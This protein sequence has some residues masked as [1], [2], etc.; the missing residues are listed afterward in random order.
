MTVSTAYSEK[1]TIGD[2]IRM[3]FNPHGGYTRVQAKV[4]NRNASAITISDPV[5]Y[6]VKAD[7]TVAGAYKLAF[8]G[9]ESTVVGLLIDAK[10]KISA[11][12]QNSFVTTAVLVR[13]PAIIDKTFIPTLD[14]LGTNSFVLATIVTSLAGVN[15][16]ILA[17]A[18]GTTVTQST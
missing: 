1:K 10:V 11:L 2:L 3:E 8:Y 16:P 7:G 6:P 17:N 5:G 13:G 4:Y 18:E 12:A 9:D 15:P 14:A